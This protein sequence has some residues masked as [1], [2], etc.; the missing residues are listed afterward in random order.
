MTV[1][2]SA[3]ATVLCTFC[4]LYN[5]LAP[6]PYKNNYNASLEEEMNIVC[7]DGTEAEN[8]EK[9]E[10]AEYIKGEPNSD[11]SSAEAPTSDCSQPTT[12]QDRPQQL[13]IHL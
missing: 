12:D 9:S 1:I 7:N 8:P 11:C 5:S 6:R 10:P 4:I 3:V 13:G 2:L